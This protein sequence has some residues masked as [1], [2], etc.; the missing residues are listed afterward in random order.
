MKVDN[1]MCTELRLSKDTR[2]IVLREVE[3]CFLIACISDISLELISLKVRTH[4]NMFNSL[5]V[6][7]KLCSFNEKHENEVPSTH[8]YTTKCIYI[9]YSLT[10]LVHDKTLP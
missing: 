7:K 9:L 1:Y 4:K 5:Q 2:C 3:R 10:N 6:G 8:L